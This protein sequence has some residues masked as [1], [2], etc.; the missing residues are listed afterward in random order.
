MGQGGVKQMEQ[1][2][3]WFQIVLLIMLLL[4]LFP[5]TLAD[6]ALPANTFTD[7]GGRLVS[8]PPAIGK[9]YAT[10]EAGTFLVYALEPEAITGWNRGLSPDLEFFIQPQYHAMPTL[11]TWNETFQTMQVNDVLGQE[12][13]LI[14]HFARINEANIAL[15]ED[16][17]EI[18][19]IPTILVDSQVQALPD[20]LRQVGKLLGREV[21]GQALATYV[22]NHLAHM[23]S[24][25]RLQASYA[26]IPVHIVSSYEAG[27]FD[28]LLDLAKMVEMPVWNNEPPLPDLVLIMPHT[29]LD[30]YRSIEEEGYKRLY[31]I[32]AY[33]SSWVEP[34]SIFSLLGL[35]WLHTIA[36]P[37]TYTS[38]L[39]ATYK[40][41][42]EVFFQ[43]NVTQELLSWTLKRSGISY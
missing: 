32:P 38:D 36:Y 21:R 19:G 5:N 25:Q 8:M 28:E 12:P 37:T 41:F 23:A 26:P 40:A 33:P 9:V 18:L 4:L 15:A 1:S 2:V 22:E 6:K 29:I 3:R 42:M 24:F 14:I 31:Q 10:T 39:A 17:Q 16:V 43:V 34:G 11:G 20:A 30:P 35:E 13:D 7:H 27:Y